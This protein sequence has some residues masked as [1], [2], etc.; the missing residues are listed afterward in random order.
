MVETNALALIV[1]VNQLQ[2]PQL[3][4]AH[5]ANEPHEAACQV[6]KVP[7]QLEVNTYHAVHKEFNGW[8]APVA[9]VHA[10]I[11]AYA[12]VAVASPVHQ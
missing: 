6:G 8:N 1:N 10:Q 11:M 3:I 2:E 9:V 12:V 5:H 4:H 7:A